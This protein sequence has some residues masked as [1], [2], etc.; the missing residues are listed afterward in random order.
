MFVTMMMTDQML[1]LPP[2]LS[3]EVPMMHHMISGDA[4]Q[5]VILVQVNPGE[6]F[7]IRMEDGALQCIQGPA[8]VPM[9]SPNGSI[10][11]IHV[12]PGYVSQVLEDNTGVRRVVVTPHSECYQ[13]SYSPALSPSHHI[14]P[15]Y[16]THPH[17]IPASHTSYYPPVSPG[18]VPPHQFYQHR[19]PPIY[20][21]VCGQGFWITV[22][23]AK[24]ETY[25][26][27]AMK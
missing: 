6:T 16:L 26:I 8:E 4:S 7:T 9:M 17:F 15:P 1:D 18:D 12:P 10:P 2:P 14:H 24:V 25:D 5:Q 19:L 22:G 21:E 13:P 27:H 23:G 20:P 3:A 11:P